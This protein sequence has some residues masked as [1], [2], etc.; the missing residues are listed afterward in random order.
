VD[1]GT[2]LTIFC[3][4]DY[5][6]KSPQNMPAHHKNSCFFL[7]LSILPSG[8]WLKV[9]RKLMTWADAPGA[10]L[11]LQLCK[12]SDIAQACL[13]LCNPMDCSLPGSSVHGIFQARVLEWAAVSFSRGSSWSRDW[14]QSP[15]LQ[16]EA[17]P[18]EPPGKKYQNIYNWSLGLTPGQKMK[19]GSL[20]VNIYSMAL[21]STAPNPQIN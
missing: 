14:T 2:Y 7:L 18:S 3:S 16:T 8:R 15:A 17:F 5:R 9:A 4:G 11:G 1:N 20:V 13:T 6:A 19:E 21:I 10:R 12:E